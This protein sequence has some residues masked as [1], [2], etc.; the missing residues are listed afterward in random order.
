MRPLPVKPVPIRTGLS[1]L[2][3]A[4]HLPTLRWSDKHEAG[5]SYWSA[6]FNPL[7]YVPG[8]ICDSQ[9]GRAHVHAKTGPTVY[10][11]G[12]PAMRLEGRRNLLPRRAQPRFGPG[13]LIETDQFSP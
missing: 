12:T 2:D 3:Q 11:C 9:Q 1:S 13:V 10:R 6:D 5:A 8:G 4:R 7:T